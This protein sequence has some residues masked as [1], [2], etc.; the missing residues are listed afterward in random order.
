[1]RYFKRLLAVC[2]AGMIFASC[3][4][5]KVWDNSI[6]ETEIVAVLF[7]GLLPTSYN[8]IPV[9]ASLVKE[10]V[11]G[12]MNSAYIGFPPGKAEMV[13]DVYWTSG[14]TGSYSSYQSSN[15][16]FSYVFEAGES[17]YLIYA[18]KEEQRGVNVY[19]TKIKALRWPPEESLEA[20]VPFPMQEGR[21]TI[22]Q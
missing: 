22:L 19:K 7:A 3:A 8:G 13:L 4:S 9:D 2:F 10:A 11:T 18:T 20:F 14:W 16:T 6:P 15:N 1:M 12:G 21:R 5:P 17:Y